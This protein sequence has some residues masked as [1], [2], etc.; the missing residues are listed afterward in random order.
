MSEEDVEKYQKMAKGKEYQ[1]GFGLIKSFESK[2]DCSGICDESLFYYT[3]PMN[4]GP[5]QSTCIVHMKDVISSNLTYMGLSATLCGLIMIFMWICQ[6]TLW[7]KKY[8]D[9]DVKKENPEEE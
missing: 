6:Y 2:F 7:K 3:L 4:R 8:Y 1:A 9:E 5:P